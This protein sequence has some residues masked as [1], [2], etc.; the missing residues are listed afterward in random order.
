MSTSEFSRSVNSRSYISI[1]ESSTTVA[2]EPNTLDLQSSHTKTSNLE[3][4]PT[5][6]SSIWKLPG[7]DKETFYAAALYLHAAR[8]ELNGKPSSREPKTPETTREFLDCLADCFARSKLQDARDH[9]SATA[10]ARNEEQKKITLYI[11]KNQSKKECEHPVSQEE[12]GVIANEN[13]V[14]AERLVDWFRDLASKDI[15]QANDDELDSHSNIFKT[16]C[17]FSWSRLEHYIGKISE[18][19]IDG[20]ERVVLNDLEVKSRDGREVA[21]FV[22][23]ECKLYQDAK[24]NLTDS[25]D[26]TSCLL[27][28]YAHLA[29]QSRKYHGF[30][31]LTDEVETSPSATKLKLKGI[32]QAVK[33][34]NYLGRL[35]AAYVKFFEFCRDKEQSGYSFEFRLL[36]SQEDEWI[37]DT[38]IEKIQSWTGDLDLTDERGA[39]KTVDGKNVVEVKT[40]ETLMDEIVETTG[41][42]ARVHCEMQLMMHFSQPNAEK[43]LDY[44]GC[45]KKSCWLCWQMILQNS[46]YSMKDTH[47]KLYPRWAFPFEFSPSQPTVA[48]GLR[49]AYNEMLF[50]IQ[51]KVIKQRAL[52]SLE[53]YLQTSA[54]MT[55]PH[56]RA[57]MSESTDQDPES[58]LFSFNPIAVPERF[59][60]VVVPALHLPAGGSLR[61]LR[62]V[63]VW[64]YKTDESDLVQ[65]HMYSAT[66]N[67]KELVFAF[68]LIT[69]PKSLSLTSGINEY[70]QGFWNVMFFPNVDWTMS[71]GYAMY[72]RSAEDTLARN[73]RVLSIWRD[74][75]DEEHQTFPWRGDVFILHLHQ[76]P[77]NRLNGIQESSPID[78][79]ACLKA[80]K[81]FFQRHGAEYS[82]K[83]EETDLSRA[84]QRLAS[85]KEMQTKISK[86]SELKS[87]NELLKLR[88]LKERLMS[89]EQSQKS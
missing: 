39:R 51:D 33:W 8:G 22:I 65:R 47:R 31:D 69:K 84:K 20:L 55:P 10:M 72:Y 46:K 42:K 18:S 53:P 17:K 54:R 85:Y 6:N 56:R 81:S 11:A 15:A 23:N 88:V 64:A 76:T 52:S 79:S 82:R 5:S 7:L 89:I 3:L 62:Q 13:N 38:Y 70:Q 25:G 35:F 44:F 83:T 2:T 60:A 57:P 58:G 40:V 49:A 4:Q 80:L 26:Q 48:E 34:I 30:R 59:P 21:K 63:E 66:F 27:A 45:S 19:D 36:P 12:L 86:L 75:H 77:S 37:G 14:F 43:C 9:V 29:G 41:N 67:D 1:P 87:K 50:L 71:P 73:P 68:Q 24:S 74:I 32:A 28:T 78:D 61:N 16:M